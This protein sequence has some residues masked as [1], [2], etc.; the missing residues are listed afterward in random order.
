MPEKINFKQNIE[1]FELPGTRQHLT[2]LGYTEEGVSF[3]VS[4]IIRVLSKFNNPE[5]ALKVFDESFPK[6]IN[7]RFGEKQFFGFLK[8]IDPTNEASH[9]FPIDCDYAPLEDWEKE[10]MAPAEIDEFNKERAEYLRSYKDE[11]LISLADER[12]YEALAT[13]HYRASKKDQVDESKLPKPRPPISTPT[14][15]QPGFKRKWR[16]K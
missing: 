7:S 4:K 3:I 5:E 15:G 8:D 14:G 2:N 12:T 6:F 11:K 9:I 1:N 10:E 13:A 16:F